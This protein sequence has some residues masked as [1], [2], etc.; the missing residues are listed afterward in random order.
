MG[1]KSHTIVSTMAGLKDSMEIK[2]FVQSVKI[3]LP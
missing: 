3:Y 2:A 1:K